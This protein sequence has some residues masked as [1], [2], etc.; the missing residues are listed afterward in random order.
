MKTAT[1]PILLFASA[2]IAATALG[3]NPPQELSHDDGE[4]AKKSSLAGSGHAVKFAVKGSNWL[5]TEVRIFGSRYGYPQPPTEDFHVWLCDKDFKSIADFPFP[6]STFKRGQPEWVS[7]KVKPARVPKEFFVC[8]GFDP[9]ATKG[10]YVSADKESSGHSYTG[11]PGREPKPF[12][13]G[14]WLIRAT[15]DPRR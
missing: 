6:Y 15:V 1:Q 13:G 7:F 14:D 12:T 8:V 5:L 10:V 4:P 3:A 11:L 9:T 2:L